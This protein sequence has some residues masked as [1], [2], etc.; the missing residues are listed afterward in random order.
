MPFNQGQYYKLNGEDI[1]N[2]IERA[3]EKVGQENTEG[4]KLRDKFTYAKTVDS[5]LDTIYN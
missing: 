1:L 5:I 2:A 4:I 3:V